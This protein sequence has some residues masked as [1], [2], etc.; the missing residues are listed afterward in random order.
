MIP[1]TVLFAFTLTLLAGLSTG[2][3]GALAVLPKRPGNR[4]LSASLGFSAGV[5]VYVS[6]LE[7]LPNGFEAIESEHPG[8]AGQWLG[9]AGFFLG[10]LVIIVI[11]RLVPEQINPHEPANVNPSQDDSE[12]SHSKAT[13]KLLRTGTITAIV[14]ALH[15]FPEGF[16]TFISGLHDASVAV[17]IAVAI[18]IHNIPEGIAVA[19]PIREATGSRHKG[20]WMALLSGLAEPIGAL[21]GYLF[22]RPFLTPTVIGMVLAAVAGIM[23]FISLDELLPSAEEF[24]EH[25]VAIYGFVVGMAVMAVSLV[26]LS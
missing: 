4:F 25:H 26:M 13:A 1:S 7:M 23:V 22:L 11:D 12:D 16:A 20:F 2:I 9:V 14:L 19:V 24:G 18:A 15:N 21:I 17:P 8:K 5:M 3:G 6:L 10:V